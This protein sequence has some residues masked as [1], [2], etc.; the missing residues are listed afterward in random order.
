M[1]RW[2]VLALL[3]AIIRAQNASAELRANA[4][5]LGGN[6]MMQKTESATDPKQKDEFRA[7]AIDFFTKIAQFY[8]GVPIAA[9]EGLWKG[10]QLLEAQAADAKDDKFKSQQL[11]RARESYKQLVKDYPESA[12]ASQAKARLAAIGEQ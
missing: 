2:A 11:S 1:S 7:Q 10:G 8:S 9:S 5:L 12:Q 3:P 4:F 6:I